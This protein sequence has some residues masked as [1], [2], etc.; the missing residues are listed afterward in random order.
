MSVHVLGQTG[1]YS[2]SK[3][4]G[5]ARPSWLGAE[6][7]PDLAAAPLHLGPR[8]DPNASYGGA[9]PWLTTRVLE[10]KGSFLPPITLAAATPPASF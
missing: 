3:H 4:L 2:S 5:T 6:R 9:S 8:G 1:L 10:V 7:E